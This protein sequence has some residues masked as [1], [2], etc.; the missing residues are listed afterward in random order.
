[1]KRMGV[2]EAWLT[3]QL[4]LQGVRDAREV[5]LGLCD[6]NKCLTLYTMKASQCKAE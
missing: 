2:D 1:M 5:Y 3:A 4:H 6:A